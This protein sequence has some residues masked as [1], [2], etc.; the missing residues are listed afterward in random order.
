MPERTKLRLRSRI[1]QLT[2]SLCGYF[3]GAFQAPLLNNMLRI[4]A[5]VLRK[6]HT[7]SASA[8]L[9]LRFEKFEFTQRVPYSSGISWKILSCCLTLWA[10]YSDLQKTVFLPCPVGMLSM[11][12]ERSWHQLELIQHMSTCKDD[13]LAE[14]FDNLN[15]NVSGISV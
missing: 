2:D 14:I 4:T 11:G 3:S 8:F 9:Y 1:L 6:R 7:S 15:F 12:F 13:F 5:C 10:Q